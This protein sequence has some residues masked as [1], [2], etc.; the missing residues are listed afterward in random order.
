M[1]I[2]F[3]ELYIFWN[4]YEIFAACALA[5]QKWANASSTLYI[6]TQKKTK[7]K[8]KPNH[9]ENYL[10][11]LFLVDSFSFSLFNVACLIE[12]MSETTIENLS[13]FQPS[14]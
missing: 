8:Q 14:F 9:Y 3:Q 12:E 6:L 10:H 11:Q 4:V 2:F 7:P 5:P 13:S 1:S